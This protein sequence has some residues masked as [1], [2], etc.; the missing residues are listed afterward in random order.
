MEVKHHRE[1][2]KRKA[3]AA[4]DMTKLIEKGLATVS[5]EMHELVTVITSSSSNLESLDTLPNELMDMGLNT[6]QIVR[7]S[8][9]FGNNPTQLRIWKDLDGSFKPEFVK[10]ILEEDK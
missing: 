7:V 10:A 4:D 3:A 9:Y 5:N 2:K 8:M 6:M 1:G